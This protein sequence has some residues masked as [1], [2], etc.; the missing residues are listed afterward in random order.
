MVSFNGIPAVVVDN[1]YSK[2]KSTKAGDEYVLLP[3]QKEAQLQKLDK[4]LQN[5]DISEGKYK[6]EKAAIENAPDVISVNG[7][8]VKEQELRP[9][10]GDNKDGLSKLNEREYQYEVN[11]LEREHSNGD[12]SDFAYKANMYMLTS[13]MPVADGNSLNV[14]A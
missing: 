4:M 5:G 3:R 14:V 7:S 2:R 12:I 6:I 1:I 9:T 11:K 8:N 13:S 10:D